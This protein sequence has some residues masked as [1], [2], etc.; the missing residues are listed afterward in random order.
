MRMRTK[1]RITAVIVFIGGLAGFIAS[2]PI[3]E[4]SSIFPKSVFVFSM[5]LA[6]LLYLSSVFGLSKKEEEKEETSFRN[7]VILFA[8]I[9]IFFLLIQPV[10]FIIMTPLFLAGVS[11]MLQLR[12][13][14]IL[15]LYP[16]GFTAFLYVSFVVLLQVPLPM[17]I[18]E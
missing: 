5:I 16:L 3:P 1:D 12:N 9:V 6:V 10:G 8:G 18:F 7:I 2:G 17:G 11:Y 14:K 15:I 13:L 4:G